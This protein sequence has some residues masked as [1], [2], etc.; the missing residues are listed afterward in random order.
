M[1][2]HHARTMIFWSRSYLCIYFPETLW[3]LE[4]P[5]HWKCIYFPWSPLNFGDANSS[6]A[7]ICIYIFSLK[8]LDFG[9]ANSLKVY[10]FSLKPF[11]FWRRQFFE[12]PYLYIYF[13]WN[14]LHFGD[15]NSLKV[16]IFSLKP[17]GFWRRQFIESPYLY[18]YFPWNPWILETP[19]HRKPLSTRGPSIPWDFES[20]GPFVTFETFEPCTPHIIYTSTASHRLEVVLC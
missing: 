7:L 20:L 9:D 5:I 16:C 3:I 6:K 15:A 17:S 11:G 4:T 10:I 1:W 2:L 13:P 14:P 19:I 8:A 12:S 18:I